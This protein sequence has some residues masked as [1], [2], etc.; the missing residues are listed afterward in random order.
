MQFVNNHVLHARASYE[1]DREAGA[2]RHLKRLWLE[3]GVL[4]DDDKPDA[5]RMGGTT[6]DWWKAAQQP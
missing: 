6:V 4:A 2:V 3:T 5:F 1:D